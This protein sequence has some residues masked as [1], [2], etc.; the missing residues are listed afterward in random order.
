MAAA[1]QEPA[2]NNTSLQKSRDSQW[3]FDKLLWILRR[4]DEV[5]S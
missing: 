2:I 4:A 5:F 1:R 3:V